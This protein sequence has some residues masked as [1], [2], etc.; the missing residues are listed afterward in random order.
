MGKLSKHTYEIMFRGVEKP[1][2]HH[3]KSPDQPPLFLQGIHAKGPNRTTISCPYCDGGF[4]QELSEMQLAPDE[5][6]ES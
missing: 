6:E 2:S 5:A 3:S 1:I 4:I